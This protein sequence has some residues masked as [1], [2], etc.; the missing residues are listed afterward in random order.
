[1]VCKNENI[2]NVATLLGYNHWGSMFVSKKDGT[3]FASGKIWGLPAFGDA[4]QQIISGVDMSKVKQVAC[5]AEY[6]L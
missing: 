3:V 5:D 6:L 4:Q 2:N 1:M